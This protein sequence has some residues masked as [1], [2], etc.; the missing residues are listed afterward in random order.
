LSTIDGLREPT[1]AASPLFQGINAMADPVQPSTSDVSPRE[2]QPH[3]SEQYAFGLPAGSIRAL[4]ALAV[5]GTAASLTAMQPKVEIDP[6]FR[7]LSFLILGGYFAHRRTAHEPEQTGPSPLFLPRGTVRLLLSLAI[8]A[9]IALMVRHHEPLKPRN[10]PALYPVI[11]MIG[12]LF[13]VLSR[14]YTGWLLRHG[15]RPKRIWADLRASIAILAAALL[16]LFAWNDAYQFLP[17]SR[18]SG[19]TFPLTNEG[20]RHTLAAIVAFYFGSRA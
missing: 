3:W 7:D 4:L 20:I 15:R 5:I 19:P 18:E 8:L 13:G 17:V 16:V 14:L 11:V 2:P 10:N 1:T 9:V 6:A 12:F